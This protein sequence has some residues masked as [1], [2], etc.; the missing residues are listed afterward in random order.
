MPTNEFDYHL[1]QKLENKTRC[2]YVK[3]ENDAEGI[4]R[5]L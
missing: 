2:N 5:T 1:E 4:F 3:E